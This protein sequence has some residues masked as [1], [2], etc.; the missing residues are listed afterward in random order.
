[1]RSIRW[2]RSGL[3]LDPA[4]GQRH[5]LGHRVPDLLRVVVVNAGAALG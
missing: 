2:I 1:M 3:D 4:S 5:L